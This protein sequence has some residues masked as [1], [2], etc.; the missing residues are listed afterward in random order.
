[1]SDL[2]GT[3]TLRTGS[4]M[5]NFLLGDHLGSTSVTTDSNGNWTAELRYRPW[6]EIRY[7]SGTTPTTYRY[8]GQREQAEIGLYYYGVRW[9]DNALGR[10]TQPDTI[11]PGTGNVQAWDRYAYGL[12]NPVKYNDPSGHAAA[13]EN[14]DDCNHL[15]PPPKTILTA[16][17]YVRYLKFAGITINGNIRV[18]DARTFYSA[19]FKMNAALH[20]KFK[21]FI[22]SVTI[23]FKY[24]T[25]G[26][27]GGEWQGNK[28]IDFWGTNAG[29]LPDVNIFH[30]FGHVI[31]QDIL[32]GRPG[33]DLESNSFYDSN[34]N[35]V[36]GIPNGSYDRQTGLGYTSSCGAGVYA[37][38]T[39]Q[40]TRAW[41]PDGNTGGEEFAD[42]F[43]NY[44]AGTI[45]IESAPGVTRFE[46]MSGWLP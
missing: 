20:W 29:Q 46:Y 38:S 35:F 3:M 4:I 14:G 21:E 12:N 16:E 5:L 44:V 45:D 10:F 11:I 37:C 22:G 2:P 15:A 9:Y 24:I 43:L 1:M 13:C 23:N 30:E 34:D 18:E 27:Y 39:E 7:T 36:M 8:T 31:E 17:Y 41:E 6:G 25:T 40:H 26:K 19:Y 33:S 28:T 42:M 32:G